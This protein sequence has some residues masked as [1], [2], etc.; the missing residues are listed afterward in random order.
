MSYRF[1]WA[2]VTK[3]NDPIEDVITPEKT[4]NCARSTSVWTSDGWTADKPKE[5][6]CV[7]L[8][9]RAIFQIDLEQDL[10]SHPKR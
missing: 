3:A 7:T 5:Q 9:N 8:R 2:G 6:E 4:A 1:G 10:A